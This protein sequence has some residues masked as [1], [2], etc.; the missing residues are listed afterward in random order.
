MSWD[1]QDQQEGLATRPRNLNYRMGENWTLSSGVRYDSRADEPQPRKRRPHGC[2]GP[3]ADASPAR[4]GRPMLSC[5]KRF[6]RSGSRDDNSRIGAGGSF[7][8]T[9][10]FN[11][12]GKFPRVIVGPGGKLGTEYLYSDR[13]TVYLNYSFENERSDNGRRARQY[14]QRFPHVS[15]SPVNSS[16]SRNGI[17]MATFELGP[18]IPWGGPRAFRSFQFW[19]KFRFRHP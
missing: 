7:R 10:R 6:R 5:R 8:L 14:G 19:R 3:A 18:T 16:P 11:F 12:V 2:G 13:T 4:A 9:D 1:K 15:D 17:P